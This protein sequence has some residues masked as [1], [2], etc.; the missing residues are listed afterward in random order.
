MAKQT[1]NW[2]AL[3]NGFDASGDLRI[4]AIVAPRLEPDADQVLKPFRD[5]VDWPAMVRAARFTLHYGAQS[6]VIPGSQTSGASRVD[7]S[8]DLPDSPTWAVLFSESTPVSGFQFKDL[9]G[10]SVLSYDTVGVN[11]LAQTLYTSLAHAASDGLPKITQIL[12]DPNWQRLIDSVAIL[13][14]MF[15][16]EKTGLRDSQKEFSR[17]LE[18]GLKLQ[19]P[20]AALLGRAQ[21][22]HTPPSLQQ[23]QDY[24]GSHLDPTDP[25]ITSKTNWRTYRRTPL[26]DKT[27][28]VKIIDFHQIVA[29]MSSYPRLLRRLGLVVDFVVAR[30][31]FSPG[32]DKL[33]SVVCDLGTP[34]ASVTRLESNN[35]THTRLSTTQF[36]A[37]PKVPVNP[38]DLRVH[39]GLLD[40]NPNQFAVLQSDVD[41]ACLKLM[42]FARSLRP[43]AGNA[44]LQVDAVTKFEKEAGAPALRNAGLMLVHRNRANML[45]NSFTN[46]KKLDASLQKA[47]Q[48]PPTGLPPELWAED[49]VRGW[50]IDIWD[51]KS[52]KWHSLCERKSEHSIGSLTVDDDREGFL[53]LAATKSSD[54][55]NPKLMWLHE[56]LLSWAGW[57]LVAPH[58]GQAVD[59]TDQP[60]NA[61]V[62]VPP[63]LPMKSVFTPNPGS[64]PRLRYGRSYKIRAR[65]ADLAANSLPTNEVDFGP[66][67]AAT[68]AVKYCRFDPLQAPSLALVRET[69]V[70]EKP[71]EGE[72]MNRISIRTFNDTPAGNTIPSTQTARRYAVE[73]RSTVKDAEL[74]GMLDAAGHVDG[75]VAMFNLLSGKDAALAEVKRA[76]R[77]VA[78]SFAVPD[79]SLRGCSADPAFR[80]HH[81]HS[82]NPASQGHPRHAAAF[83]QTF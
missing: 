7:N 2:T 65:M 75:S 34:A 73:S 66:A 80:P 32:P 23:A 21:L 56:A 15:G 3:P 1:L 68:N 37:I 38:D 30:G 47:V 53:R 24:S 22:F 83:H 48:T 14:R 63:G 52:A 72:T 59:K 13:D 41:G 71:L 67:Q 50:R 39:D 11:A 28:F 43:M 74:H 69:G 78:E 29:A 55:N 9:T 17:F 70:V 10:V 64:L 76:R 35:T 26:P 77:A 79:P 5:F 12:G 27:D 19:P 6:V 45:Q 54:G 42:N 20:L 46:A 16:D 31:V 57:S 40:L 44:L 49:V 36:L 61:D 60:A 25:R 8:V 51:D 18:D 62:E 58:P 4:S 81:A 33:L 82:A